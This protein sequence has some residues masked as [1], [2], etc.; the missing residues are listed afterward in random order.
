MV[1]EVPLDARSERFLQSVQRSANRV[2]RFTGSDVVV[3]VTVEA[4]AFDGAGAIKAAIQEVARIYPLEE[5][6]P[7]GAQRCLD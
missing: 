7:R 4:H 5:F 1:V 2:L 6:E 3:V